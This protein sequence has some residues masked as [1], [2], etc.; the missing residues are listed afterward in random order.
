MADNSNSKTQNEVFL[1]QMERQRL[2]KLCN[3]VIDLRGK[4]AGE[5]QTY[6]FG[7]KTH[8]LDDRGYLLAKQLL[9]RFDGRYTF[10][11]YETLLTALKTLASSAQKTTNIPV[12]P[13]LSRDK[14]NV[15]TIPFNYQLQRKEPR[16]NFSTPA[17]IHIADVL[18]H[19]ATIDITTSAIRIALKRAFTLNQGDTVA[20][21]FPELATKTSPDLLHK[22]PYKVIKI[23][24]DELRTYVILARNRK[25]N[26]AVTEWFDQWS[27]K[28]NSPEHL[29]LE[30]ELFNIAS[31]YYLRL[32]CQKFTHPLF[33]LSHSEDAEIIKASHMTAMAADSL[34]V[35]RDQNGDVDLDF[36]PIKQVLSEQADYLLLLSPQGEKLI[37][38]IAKRDEPATVASLLLWHSQQKQS[39][40]LLLHTDKLSCDPLT[41]EQEISAIAEIDSN[42]AEAFEQ[43]LAALTTLLTVTNITDSCLHLNQPQKVD[44]PIV[45]LPAAGSLND[46]KPTPLQHN[47]TRDTQRFFIR[48]DVNLY[49]NKQKFNVM[50]N[51]VSESGLS[52]N[53]PG[54]VD[55]DIGTRVHLEFIRWQKLTHKVRLESIPFI[56]RN[57]HFWSGETQFGLQRD[58]RACAS[59]IN[60]F[61]SSVIELNKEQLAENNLN[62]H[63]SQQSQ[64]YAA[65][66][67]AQL[68]STPIYLGMDSDNRRILQAVATTDNNT[69]RDKHELWLALQD[70]VTSISE[71]LKTIEDKP[72]STVS[73]GVYCYQQNN[74]PW[75]ISTE[76]SFANAAAKTLFIN[77][78]LLCDQYYFFHCSLSPLTLNS[79]AK[80]ADLYHKL[81]QLRSH[82]QHKVKQIR[83]VL[84][85][86]FAVGELTDITDILAAVY[87]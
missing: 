22:V 62:I 9:D 83:E 47:A 80:E 59:S 72:D 4:V 3:R 1:K 74:G 49:V 82:S 46:I 24:H 45:N 21:S 64:V 54:H 77:R 69:A 85:S 28:Y 5:C 38:Y 50:T 8:Y 44:E 30:N 6:S 29:D 2:N 63:L 11:V 81:A 60:K 10:G 70:S 17:E 41:F 14:S 40:L 48:T 57:K 84:Q 42:D 78:A 87:R 52:L 12:A 37:S 31:H 34:H 33:W 76:Q 75:Q 20:I 35:L 32:Y 58:S 51:E 86:L 15:Q 55:I 39:Q 13:I 71:L 73:F 23:S 19:A 43:S 56:V 66:L 26:T 67:T 79:V 61:F 36:L 7:G 16:I 53:I 68:N 25:D 27:L 65:L 18:Y